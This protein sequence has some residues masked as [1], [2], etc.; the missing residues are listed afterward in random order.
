MKTSFSSLRS[1]TPQSF[2]KIIVP[3]LVISAIAL[4][5]FALIFAIRWVQSPFPGTFLYPRLVVADSYNPDW[6]ARQ[7]G[8]QTGDHVLAADDTPVS[9][10]RD[11]FLLLEQKEINDFVQLMLERNPTSPD[12]LSN[13]L[14]IPLSN[15]LWQDLLVFFW[16][17]FLI[18]IVSLF[19]G[20]VVF[21]L[22]GVEQ[23]GDIF[24]IF[25]VFV[26]ILAG[27]IFDQYTLHFLTFIWVIVLPFT[28]ATLLHLT[29]VFPKQ[30]RL[31]RRQYWLRF[32]PY[33]IAIIFGVIN[34]YGLY[35]S[36]NPRL[37]LTV[38]RI[39]NFGFI[40]LSILLFLLLQLNARISTFSPLV[41]QQ[42]SIVFWGGI[43]AFS[44]AAI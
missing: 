20:I 40:G 15:F 32:V 44:P 37:Y 28:G 35:I 9:S 22:S 10:S 38:I 23:G 42:T 11:L 18:G 33:G 5:V 29:F 21:R 27:A 39:W 19:L 7:L 25:C 8:I 2:I 34:L 3:V 4:N 31:A 13:S 6:N 12:N 26:S 36:P 14:N 30:T 16:L 41:R 1:S 43:I 24:V 17:P